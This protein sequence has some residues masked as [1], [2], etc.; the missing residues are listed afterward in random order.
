MAFGNHEGQFRDPETFSKVFKTA[1][2]RCARALGDAALP[3]IG[4]AR[5]AP[6]ARHD[7]ADRPRAG[8]CRVPAPR[9][10]ERRRHDDRLRARAAG[11]SAGGRRLVRPPGG[12][13]GSMSRSGISL[14][15][16]RGWANYRPVTCADVVRA[17]G[18]EPPRCFHQQDLNLPRIPIAPR[19]L[20]CMVARRTQA[21][22]RRRGPCGAWRRGRSP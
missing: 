3:E 9:P 12:G 14:A 17:G 11:Q 2:R 8:A 7:R 15:G 10:Y 18:L 19:P 1:Q 6:H 13:G 22:V 20:T 21:L 4:H 16:R 5:P